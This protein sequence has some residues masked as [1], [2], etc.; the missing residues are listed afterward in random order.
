VDY[1]DMGNPPNA[2]VNLLGWYVE[3]VDNSGSVSDDFVLVV[4]VDGDG[5]IGVS[6]A[7][8]AVVV[9]DRRLL[10]TFQSSG[11]PHE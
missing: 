4:W 8:S 6:R 7:D 3:R 10:P 11:T 9:T 5:L 2:P 1:A